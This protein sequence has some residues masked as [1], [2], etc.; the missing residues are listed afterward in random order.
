[1]TATE[2][3]EE[4]PRAD[5]PERATGELLRR[6]T[7]SATTEGGGLRLGALA[8][9]VAELLRREVVTAPPAASIAEA[10]RRMTA[11]GV[12]SIPVV[13]AAGRP[14][15]ILTDTDLRREVVAGGHPA[16]A[17]VITLAK[18]PVVTIG[19][20]APAL[21][22]LQRM[23]EH[24]IAHLVVLDAAGR[25]SGVLS[26]RDLMLAEAHSPAAVLREVES[27]TDLDGLARARQRV[28]GMLEAMVRTGIEPQRATR[29]VTAL[30]DRA[31]RRALAWAEAAT[32]AELGT[33]P[34][35]Y[36]W[37]ALGS[38]GREEQTLATDQ[39]NALIYEEATDAAGLRWLERFAERA[40]ADLDRLGFP[41]CRGGVMARSPFWR[42]SLGGWTAQLQ[43]WTDE[44]SEQALMETAIFCDF[45]ALHGD[46]ALALQLREAVFGA[47]RRD[48]IFLAHLTRAALRTRPP[49]GLL[50]TFLVERSGE[51][52]DTL[53][54]KERGMAPLVDAARVLALRH[55]IAATNTF[56][57][58]AAAAEARAIPAT[59][60]EDAREAYGFLMLLRLQ[61]QLVQLGQGIALDSRINPRE[62]PALQRRSL[63]VA[64]QVVQAVQGA[65]SDRL[66]ALPTG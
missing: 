28:A 52:R 49:L 64:F 20:A 63:Q 34:P 11:A 3:E 40:N 27:A 41:L 48:A 42:R 55:D 10:A 50:R 17:P 13:D 22:A 31:T 46:G 26:M 4:I 39:D 37:L 58:L 43:R 38:E 57:R 5:V 25:V 9:P 66:G 16:E 62:L 14:L 19:A 36:C 32:T 61:H 59:L 7:A 6:A 24:G 8:A 18:R 45:R 56:E 54:L 44:A 1:M 33:E 15:G 47:V 60:A 51:H 12:G 23:A 30:N 65:L 35:R 29:L 53:D 21:E 2:S